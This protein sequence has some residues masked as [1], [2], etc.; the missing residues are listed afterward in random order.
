MLIY[1]VQ[2][3]QSGWL[4]WI[5]WY[6]D[7]ATDVVVEQR[8]GEA[9]SS[10]VASLSGGWVQKNCIGNVLYLCVGHKFKTRN[11]YLKNCETRDM[12]YLGYVILG[13]A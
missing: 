1:C 13:T 10:E 12:I 7:G 2:R 6:G 11:A 8:E 4:D 9:L 3:C 5:L